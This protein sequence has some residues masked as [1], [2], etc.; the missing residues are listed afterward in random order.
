MA[1]GW[2]IVLYTGRGDFLVKRK[3]REGVVMRMCV[4]R[5]R[6]MYE[7]AHPMMIMSSAMKK[8]MTMRTLSPNL[9]VTRP[10][11]TQ[12]TSTPEIALFKL[13]K[14]ERENLNR[15]RKVSIGSTSPVDRVFMTVEWGREVEV[16]GAI[17][18]TKKIP[19]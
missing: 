15:S 18:V 1:N 8:S 3:K 11:K 4:K 19:V 16:P 13:P 10:K 2:S 5:P 9:D 14:I 7:S 6:R 17:I 12:N